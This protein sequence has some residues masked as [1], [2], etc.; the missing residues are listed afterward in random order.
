M[1]QIK[2]VDVCNLKKLRIL[3]AIFTVLAVSACNVVNPGSNK[4]AF[5]TNGSIVGDLGCLNNNYKILELSCHRLNEGE[6]NVIGVREFLP[7]TDHHSDS[8]KKLTIAF[9]GKVKAGQ[10]FEINDETK[11]FYSYGLTYGLA[12]VGCFGV[13]TK[14]VINILNIAEDKIDLKL[15][16]VFNM[17]SPSGRI[18]NCKE[19]TYSE[20]IS[21]HYKPYKALTAWDG[22]SDE[23][24]RGID[25]AHP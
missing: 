1:M 12:K 24:S 7:G 17:K 10:K 23:K 3:F 13:A 2:P 21:A 9:N 15:D 19:E 5:F 14:G 22:V 4:T 18:D 25:E 11:A 6:N 8:F 20:T 16:I